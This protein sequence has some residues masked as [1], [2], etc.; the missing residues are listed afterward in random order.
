MGGQTYTITVTNKYGSSG[1]G[2]K[3]KY[4]KGSVVSGSN[5]DLCSGLCC[6]QVNAV[7]TTFTYGWKAPSED[8]G[9]ITFSAL[10]GRYSYML[11][12]TEYTSE[13][14]GTVLTTITKTTTT[15]T[16]TTKTKTTTTATTTTA[17]ETSSTETSSTAT[18]STLS[19]SLTSTSAT[20]S[21]HTGSTTVTT[22]TTSSTLS[23]LS[24]SSSLSS[25]T[26]SSTTS[27]S[28]ATEAPP[29]ARCS[30][31]LEEG[32]LTPGGKCDGPQIEIEATGPA[33][34]A[35]EYDDLE[36]IKT[37]L[38]D[39]MG[40][41]VETKDI[42]IL[43]GAPVG[44][45]RRAGHESAKLIVLI[46]FTSSTSLADVKVAAANIQ[47]ATESLN[48]E[49]EINIVKVTV[50][51]RIVAAPIRCSS[52]SSGRMVRAAHGAAPPKCEEPQIEIKVA[53]DLDDLSEDDKETIIEELKD[54]IGD[55]TG[56]KFY[57]IE[58]EDRRMQRAA[59]LSKSFVIL[60]VFPSAATSDAV[61]A[62]TD[63]LNQEGTLLNGKI[64]IDTVKA[65]VVD[66]ATTPAPADTTTT[67]DDN[68]VG[69][70]GN[71]ESVDGYPVGTVIAIV[72]VVTVVG[73]VVIA[74]SLYGKTGTRRQS[75]GGLQYEDGGMHALGSNKGNSD[76]VQN[77][78]YNE[79]Q[80]QNSIAV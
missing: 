74:A 63:S 62:A 18:S 40:A 75:L 3:L 36:L 26:T 46:T 28:T 59:H 65:L 61:K 8:A 72:L 58:E 53:G 27:S 11:S 68:I 2:H 6:T 54:I 73:F 64:S 52:S 34:D 51:E 10:C 79:E 5:K 37:K 23:P 25:S 39:A 20:S 70:S 22:T 41:D 9:D 16:S 60:I 80:N 45:H 55:D 12:S 19:V 1:G 76:M 69:Q 57:F 67:S 49:L 13:F 33:V 24:S 35:I 31:P 29:V 30:A 47:N 38:E 4:S 21:T 7:S 50:F 42:Q 48:G 56:A 14:S 17:T 15:K 44:R 66:E 71:I 77:P 78:V 32:A 43:D